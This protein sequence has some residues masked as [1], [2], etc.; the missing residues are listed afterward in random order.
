MT[1]ENIDFSKN[2]ISGISFLMHE[3]QNSG[4]AKIAR[5]LKICLR[6]VCLVIEG[7]ANE[8]GDIDHI[9]DSDLFVAIGFLTK[10]AS[11]KDETLKRDVL[12]E[13]EGMQ[14]V[15]NFRRN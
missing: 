3:A 6:D 10:Y 7:E 8:I 15:I 1:P 13:I 9:L 2:I 12:K 11:I 14:K 5:I 4:N